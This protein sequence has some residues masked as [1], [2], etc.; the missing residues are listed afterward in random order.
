MRKT[1]LLAFALILALGSGLRSSFAHSFINSAASI[2]NV[3]IGTNKGVTQ[4]AT[5]FGTTDT[6]Y[7]TAEVAE[8]SEPVNVK[9]QLVIEDIPGMDPGPIKG[10]D[11][12]VNLVSSGRADFTFSPP[13]KGGRKGSMWSTLL[14]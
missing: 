6:V 3:K 11:V 4:E 10:L 12:T 5:T 1:Y 13:N 14:C 9:A 2:T 8:V 7:A